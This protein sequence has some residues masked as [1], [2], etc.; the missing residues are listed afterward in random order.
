MRI[1]FIAATLLIF[2]GCYYVVVTDQQGRDIRSYNH[3]EVFFSA[4]GDTVL[5]D[6]INY[7]YGELRQYFGGV[8]YGY[9]K[10]TIKSKYNYVR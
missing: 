10:A 5:V 2:T 3:E 1:I 9:F 6:S 4:V 7:Q 8:P